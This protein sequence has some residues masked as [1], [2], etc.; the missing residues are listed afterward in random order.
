MYAII[1]ICLA[2]FAHCALVMFI[3]NLSLLYMME[4][5]KYQIEMLISEH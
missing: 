3:V 1:P 5:L 2:Y 4:V